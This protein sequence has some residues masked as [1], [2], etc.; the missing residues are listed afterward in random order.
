MAKRP[1]SPNHPSRIPIKTGQRPE[2]NSDS[3]Q[4]NKPRGFPPPA[5]KPTRQNPNEA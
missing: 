1:T 3:T 5:T 2:R 4:D